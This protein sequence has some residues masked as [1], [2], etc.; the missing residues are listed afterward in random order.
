MKEYE[1]GLEY[2]NPLLTD[3]TVLLQFAD[4]CIF[5]MN[6]M[7]QALDSRLSMKYSMKIHGGKI[8]KIKIK[9]RSDTKDNT[10]ELIL[11]KGLHLIK[12]IAILPSPAPAEWIYHGD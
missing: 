2:K 4:N 11:R 12:S 6:R 9:I 7:I 8:A 1:F 3:E 5:V 10:D